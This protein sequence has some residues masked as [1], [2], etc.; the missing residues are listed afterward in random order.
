MKIWKMD[1]DGSNQVQFTPDDEYA[2]WFPHPSPDG[3][4][5]VFLSYHRS[6]EGHPPNKDVLLRLMPVGG[7]E[8]RTL[9]RLFGGQGTLNVHSWSPDSRKF[10]FVNYRLVPR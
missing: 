8:V 1:A 5:I 7:G 10:A 2:D 4:Y 3:K 6:V 9:T